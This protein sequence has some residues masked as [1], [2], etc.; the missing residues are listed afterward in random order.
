[1]RKLIFTAFLF[2]LSLNIY[3]A[4]IGESQMAECT[5]SVQSPRSQ[6]TAVISSD[7]SASTQSEESSAT[8]R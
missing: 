8:D 5:E 3:A 4:Q 2:G 6:E 1:M 7:S